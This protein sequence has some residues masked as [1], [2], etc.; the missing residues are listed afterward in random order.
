MNTICSLK[1][2]QKGVRYC[3]ELIHVRVAKENQYS[4]AE[5]CF[6]ELPS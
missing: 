1:G 2:L 3:R 4:M 5:F 6:S